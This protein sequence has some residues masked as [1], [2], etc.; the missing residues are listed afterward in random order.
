M[1]NPREF[2]NLRGKLHKT[3]KEL[4]QLLGTSIKAVHSYEQGWRA[5]PGHVERQMFFLASRRLLDP[6]AK[7]SC[8]QITR[9]PRD[10][11]AQCPAKEFKAYKLCWFICGTQCHGVVHDTWKEKMAFCRT[12]PVFQPV[13]DLAVTNE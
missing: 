8:W 9:C 2:T 3:Q 7:K 10:R 13:L 5:I 11:R 12:C 1:M 4:S 6:K